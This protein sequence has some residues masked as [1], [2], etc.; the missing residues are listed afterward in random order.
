MNDI[1]RWL[2]HQC[3]VVHAVL[4]SVYLPPF[5][6]SWTKNM[7]QPYFFFCSSMTNIIYKQLNFQLNMLLLSMTLQ[8]ICSSNTDYQ[9]MFNRTDC[10]KL[11]VT[12]LFITLP[13]KLQEYFLKL[14]FYITFTGRL[15]ADDNPD[16]APSLY[17]RPADLK[18][19]PTSTKMENAQKVWQESSTV[20]NYFPAHQY[21]HKKPA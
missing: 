11:S 12:K 9:P 19:S 18:L 1:I 7:K 3:V 6:L 20:G 14:L 8:A 16:N 10:F 2:A 21:H 17:L 4:L 15:S 13:F 5:S